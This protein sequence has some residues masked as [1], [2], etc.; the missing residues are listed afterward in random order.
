M[1][2]ISERPWYQE[3]F[4]EE[5]LRAWAPTL[6]EERAA[7]EVEGIVTLLDLPPG[8][9]ILD[10]CCGHGRIAIPLAERGYQITGQD[11]SEVFLRHARQ[12]AAAR[13]VSVRWVHGDMRAIPF[14]GEFDAIINIFTSFGYLESEAED[15]KV[16]AQVAAALKPGGLFLLE[17]IHR[18]RMVRGYRPHVI[19]RHDDGLIVLHEGEWDHLAGRNHVSITLI[20]PDGARRQFRHSVRL[21]T[22][23]ELARMLDA[24]GLPVEAH[25]GGL[26]GSEFTFD[27]RRLVVLARKPTS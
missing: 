16:L 8:S 25:Y 19:D 22:L 17:Y 12:D 23:A 7:R 21:Y 24:V 11:L 20:E 14:A 13:G 3:L 18:D 26:D 9:A 6:T 5:Y 4:G 15:A 1:S 10:L 27:S 2:V